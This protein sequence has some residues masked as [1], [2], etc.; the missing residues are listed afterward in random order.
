MA[1]DQRSTLPPGA[2]DDRAFLVAAWVREDWRPHAT[3]VRYY[4]DGQRA[5]IPSGAVDWLR[6]LASD[7]RAH[8]RAATAQ[9]LLARVGGAL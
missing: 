6:E 7:P 1:P 5:S 4:L 3:A 9:R 8:A 2:A